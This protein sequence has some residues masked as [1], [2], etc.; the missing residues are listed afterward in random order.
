MQN[1]INFFSEHAHTAFILILAVYF[2]IKK[3]F[4]P[5]KVLLSGKNRRK[6]ESKE[7]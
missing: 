6:D 4:F 2:I 7:K 5:D 3:T 1:I